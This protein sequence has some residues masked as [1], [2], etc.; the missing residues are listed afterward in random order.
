MAFMKTIAELHKKHLKADVY[1]L[2]SGPSLR[3]LPESFFRN[4]I[5][6]G[7]NYAY[8]SIRPHY[9]ITIHPYIIPIRRDDWNCQ[10]ITKTKESDK[11]WAIHKA[12]DNISD[13][14]LFNN[15]NDL[16]DFTYLE[17][18]G[19]SQKLY[20]GCGIQ[21]GAL[22]LAA[23]MGASNAILCGCDMAW[24][25][26]EH[27]ST[28]QHTQFH[29][30]NPLDVYDEYYYYT[31]KVREQLR[32]LYGMNTFSMTPFLGRVIERD[33]CKLKEELSLPDL[34]KPKDIEHVKRTT[35]LQKTFI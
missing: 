19:T 8:K 24:I 33:Y 26:G 9:S 4:K 12:N 11:S 10:W 32:Q 25:A 5:T 1:I 18:P 2:G 16:L 20:V 34:P 15:N 17:S 30:H 31:V 14:Y 29:G 7:L 28:D 13:F 35:S 6:I 3:F 23:K 22:H 27:H 21:T